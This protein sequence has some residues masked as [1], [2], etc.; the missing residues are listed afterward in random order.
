MKSI[1]IISSSKRGLSSSKAIA[2]K[3][4]EGAEIK[5]KGLLPI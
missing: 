1:T 4:K 5:N 2:L 3:I